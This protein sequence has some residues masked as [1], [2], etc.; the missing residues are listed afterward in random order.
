MPAITLWPTSH[1]DLFSNATRG[2][3]GPLI[4]DLDCLKATPGHLIR[5]S[6]EAG[7]VANK[8]L[9]GFVS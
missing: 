9:V 6:P 7:R 2:V 5:A 3:L 4:A 8:A 1:I